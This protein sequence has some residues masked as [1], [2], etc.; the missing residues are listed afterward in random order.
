MTRI[1]G[2][3]QHK[4]EP[5][6]TGVNPVR[7]APVPEHADLTTT[8]R[9]AE[10]RNRPLRIESSGAA[11]PRSPTDVE[12]TAEMT[13]GTASTVKWVMLLFGTYAVGA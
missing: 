8:A 3:A 6:N 4:G 13:P 12:H 5:D 11:S 9:A 7:R 2:V 10:R 1:P